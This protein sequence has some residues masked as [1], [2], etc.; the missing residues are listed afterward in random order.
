MH[1]PVCIY[2]HLYAGELRGHAALRRLP[3]LARARASLSRRVRMHVH[4]LVECT[5]MCMS[6]SSAH[7][8][9]CP[10]RARR[11]AHTYTYGHMHIYTRV[12]LFLVERGVMYTCKSIY[13]R[14]HI[15]ARRARRD[16]S[17][18]GL[19]GRQALPHQADWPRLAEC[20]GSPGLHLW[21]L[22]GPAGGQFGRPL[23]GRFRT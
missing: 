23:P 3:P 14:A 9:T 17:K 20:W 4:A 1:A 19:M 12:R 13:I 15:Y 2:I 11:D 16:A 10:R 18:E 22:G 5:C 7:A 21:R 8:C 6:S